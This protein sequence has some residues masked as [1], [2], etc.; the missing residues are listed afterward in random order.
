MENAITPYSA[1]K[2]IFHRGG[3]LS[4]EGRNTL[5]GAL[6]GMGVAEGIE[7]DIQIS[8]DNTLWIRH[9]PKIAKCEDFSKACF[10]ELKDSEIEERIG[11]G[12]FDAERLEPVFVEAS[13]NFPSTVLVLDCKAWTPCGVR[14]INP[15]ASMKKMGKEIIRM[16]ESYGL[17]DN[18]IVDSEVKAILRKVKKNSNIKTFYRSFGSFE[19][20]TRG[21]FGVNADGVSLD[22]KRFE[23]TKSDIDLLHQ[24]GLRVMLWTMDNETDLENAIEIQPDYVFTEL[25]R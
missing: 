14:E 11:C 2:L 6:Y 23:M 10:A 18:I 7:L 17:V 4:G 22:Q 20:A 24:K 16:S 9:D 13:A 1:P 15:I 8:F 12:E 25:E 19:K 3:G 21:A 5:V